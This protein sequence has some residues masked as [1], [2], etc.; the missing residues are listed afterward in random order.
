MANRDDVSRELAECTECGAVYAA[1]QWPDGRIKT[2][3]SESCQ[4]GSTEFSL[5]ETVAADDEVEGRT[6]DEAE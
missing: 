2:I 4:C 1:R 5:V 6:P 3:G